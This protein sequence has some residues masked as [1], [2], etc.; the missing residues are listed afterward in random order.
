MA[1]TLIVAK[2]AME[3]IL[4]NALN[5]QTIRTEKQLIVAIAIARMAIIMWPIT[6]NANYAIILGFY[7]KFK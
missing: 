4:M 3:I 2:N 7:Y 1:I 5:A 6:K